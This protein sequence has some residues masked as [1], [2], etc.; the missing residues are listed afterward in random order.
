MQQRAQLSIV[1]PQTVIKST[2]IERLFP[3]EPRSPMVNGTNT[4]LTNMSAVGLAK[5]MQ[6]NGSIMKTINSQSS[7]QHMHTAADTNHNSQAQLGFSIGQTSRI[8]D[9]HR[10]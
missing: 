2:S 4:L 8:L 10:D 9:A 3:T 7:I 6:S 5:N 1:K